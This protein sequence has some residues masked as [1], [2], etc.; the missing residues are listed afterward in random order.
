[1]QDLGV[2]SGGTGSNGEALSADGSVVAGL[3][4]VGLNQHAF[5]WTAADGITDLGLMS[6][7][8][9]AIAWSMSADGSVLV[10]QGGTSSGPTTRAFRWTAP[11]GYEDLG[12]FGGTSDTA[13]AFAVSA[14]GLVVFGRSCCTQNGAFR[15]TAQG[16]MEFLGYF[17]GAGFSEAFATNADGS[18][19]IGDCT[20]SGNPQY[21][22][23]FR[24]AAQGGMQD[25]GTLPGIPSSQARA[26]SADGEV[27]TGICFTTGAADGHAFLWTPSLGMVD[28]NAYLPT[29]GA[30]LSGWTLVH[31]SGVS[32]D[33]LKIVGYGTHNGRTE[34]W[35][36]SLPRCGS[37]DF[38][39]DGAVATD[40][41]IEAFFACLSGN[42]PPPP[43][44]SS[45]D[46]NGDGASGTDADIEAFFRVLA[47]G[48][49]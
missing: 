41:D 5:R 31:A 29:L 10:G 45:A 42:C 22:H 4:V 16:G 37:A 19:A 46:F 15:W 38:N 20:F 9:R 30:D 28:L 11:A 12:T 3:S 14:D 35:L 13:Y 24:W 17:P 47:G 25:L 26:M 27:V 40:S 33:G 7:W 23:S 6:G 8:T 44:T 2:V 43:C 48:T 21:Y 49:C 39:C 34:S 36:A 1:M 32:A 18:V